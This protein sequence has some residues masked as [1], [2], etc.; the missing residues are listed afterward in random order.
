M[1]ICKELKT[2]TN[3]IIFK[4]SRA[5]ILCKNLYVFQAQSIKTFVFIHI[6]DTYETQNQ[7]WFKSLKAREHK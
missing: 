4:S 2:C 3:L 6:S 5:F 1:K 7:L